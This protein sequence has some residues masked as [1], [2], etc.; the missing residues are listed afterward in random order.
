MALNR[1]GLVFHRQG[2]VSKAGTERL[3][4]VVSRAYERAS[5]IVTTN[6]GSEANKPCQTG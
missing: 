4:D 3:F 2:A 5:L 6:L 1:L